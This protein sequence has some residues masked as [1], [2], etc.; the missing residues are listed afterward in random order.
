MHCLHS[1]ALAV[2][3]LSPLLRRSHSPT[4]FSRLC[5]TPPATPCTRGWTR[6]TVPALRLQGDPGPKDSINSS[7]PSVHCSDCNLSRDR[8]ASLTVPCHTREQTRQHHGSASSLV[9]AV[10]GWMRSYRRQEGPI[11]MNGACRNTA[12][13][14]AP[15][16][17]VT[18]M[19]RNIRYTGRVLNMSVQELEN[20]GGNAQSPLFLL[21]V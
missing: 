3:G 5:S 10:R 4:A 18:G 17:A 15:P 12:A 11:H 9:E 16:V 2:A 19:G 1:Q 7:F 13:T 8:P 6:Q 21:T 20:L 14:N